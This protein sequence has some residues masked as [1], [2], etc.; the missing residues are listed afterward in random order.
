MSSRSPNGTSSAV[1]PIR[2]MKSQT[3]SPARLTSSLWAGSAL[4]LGIAINSASSA[5]QAS[6]TRR[7]PMLRSMR[8]VDVTLAAPLDLRDF[9]GDSLGLALEQDAILV[10]ETR[11]RFRVEAG[12]AFY[13]VALLVPGDR[14]DAAL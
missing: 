3:H 14:F 9:Y 6:S 2:R 11:L 5:R 1:P 10:G 13:H 4:T 8:F 7:H 12:G